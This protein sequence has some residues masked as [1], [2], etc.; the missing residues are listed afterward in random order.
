MNKGKV[1]FQRAQNAR[2]AHHLHTEW[3]SG[4]LK[5]NKWSELGDKSRHLSRKFPLFS[6]ILRKSYWLKFGAKRQQLAKCWLVA[7]MGAIPFFLD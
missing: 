4:Q 6:L 3:D 7:H 5:H 2:T 1:L